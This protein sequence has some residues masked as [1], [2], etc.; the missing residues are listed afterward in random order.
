MLIRQIIDSGKCLIYAF[1]FKDVRNG[2]SEEAVENETER[3]REIKVRLIRVSLCTYWRAVS[4][5]I[6]VNDGNIYGREHDY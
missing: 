3:E 6:L 4:I 2:E 5:G 1:L